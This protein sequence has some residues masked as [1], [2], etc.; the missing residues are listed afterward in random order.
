MTRFDTR[1]IV[2][3]LAA[4]E[5]KMRPVQLKPNGISN[6]GRSDASKQSRSPRFVEGNRCLRQSKCSHRAA[7]GEERAPAHPQARA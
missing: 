1:R 3:F 6:T 7:L 4:D 2:L 5:A